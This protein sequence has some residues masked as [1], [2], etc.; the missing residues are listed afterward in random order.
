MKLRAMSEL[1]DWIK[2][3]PN[4]PPHAFD[5][6]GE[7]VPFQMVKEVAL[8][9]FD[10]AAWG[11]VRPLTVEQIASEVIMEIDNAIASRVDGSR[12]RLDRADGRLCGLLWIASMDDLISRLGTDGSNESA[13]QVY[14][15]AEAAVRAVIGAST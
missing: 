15:E 13:M 4:G 6:I 11:V 1:V 9:G 14:A 3:N 7:H 10:E 8:E 12:R 5:A 2:K